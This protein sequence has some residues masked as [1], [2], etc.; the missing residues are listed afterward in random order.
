MHLSKPYIRQCFQI[1]IIFVGVA[2]AL[3]V[4]HKYTKFLTKNDSDD[5]IVSTNSVEG[6]VGRPHLQLDPT[7][8]KYYLMAENPPVKY[9]VENCDD[10]EA[11]EWELTKDDKTKFYYAD[12]DCQIK[13]E[14]QGLQCN[15]EKSDDPEGGGWAYYTPSG[16]NKMTNLCPYVVEQDGNLGN[17]I[18]FDQNGSDS[19]NSNIVNH[20]NLNNGDLACEIQGWDSGN[21]CMKK[22]CSLKSV[23]EADGEKCNESSPPDEC[24][25]YISTEFNDYNSRTCTLGLTAS[26]ASGLSCNSTGTSDGKHC[27]GS[28]FNDICWN[29]FNTKR[30]TPSNVLDIFQ[31]RNMT[32]TYKT[33]PIA[34]KT[35]Q[36][37]IS[38]LH[39]NDPSGNGKTCMRPD[40]NNHG[41]AP[42]TQSQRLKW[43]MADDGA[44][45]YDNSDCD[46]QCDT[47]WAGEAC[48]IQ[49]EVWPGDDHHMIFGYWQEYDPGMPWPYIKPNWHEGIKERCKLNKD[50]EL[51]CNPENHTNSTFRFLHPTTSPNNNPHFKKEL[52]FIQNTD[53]TTG[54]S[55]F[56]D[57]TGDHKINCSYKQPTTIFHH[58]LTNGQLYAFHTK[59][60]A[61]L[62][63]TESYLNLQTKDSCLT[64]GDGGEDWSVFYGK[65]KTY[66]DGP[67]QPCSKFTWK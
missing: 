8:G 53:Q 29:K 47:G 21:V 10:T 3:F 15:F 26:S 50:H 60:I 28:Q 17:V 19:K 5:I 11:Q 4:M 37:E 67:K 65:R 59:D 48:D 7:N 56:C 25:T 22:T 1:I 6:V 20:N 52:F 45:T 18:K 55:T 12:N 16:D 27:N 46:C 51:E 35:D 34:G 30:H 14:T 33:S 64:V 24:E 44:I 62:K 36:Y 63:P 43:S 2:F 40:C 54:D 61:N 38:S 39:Y 57:M 32:C 66:E 31:K 58:D 49:V 23:G 41:V 9:R 13:Q 42:T